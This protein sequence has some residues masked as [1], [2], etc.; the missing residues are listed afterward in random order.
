LLVPARH[1]GAIAAVDGGS[2]TELS[3]SP[4]AAP[5]GAAPVGIVVT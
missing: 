2:L 4:T 5:A 1:P 3:G